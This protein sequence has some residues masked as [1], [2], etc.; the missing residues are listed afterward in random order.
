[1]KA[2]FDPISDSMYLETV[3]E[4]HLP[5]GQATALKLFSVSSPW[6]GLASNSAKAAVAVAAGDAIFGLGHRRYCFWSQPVGVQADTRK[7]GWSPAK[8]RVEKSKHFRAFRADRQ[9]TS[10]FT[11]T[12]S[13]ILAV[14]GLAFVAMAS[15]VQVVQ[16][17]RRR[18]AATFPKVVASHSP[19]AGESLQTRA[20]AI[21]P[22]EGA[23]PCGDTQGLG[24]R[25]SCIQTTG[26]ETQ[27]GKPESYRIMTP[28]GSG[29]NL[30]G[31][32]N[33]FERM[34]TPNIP[35][36]KTDFYFMGTDV[37]AGHSDDQEPAHARGSA[38]DFGH[39][40]LR[41]LRSGDGRG[42]H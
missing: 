31:M 23:V 7:H 37:A 9:T 28:M 32:M 15:C 22:E 2:N 24:C 29:T 11:L 27:T 36:L 30:F 17:S 5:P 40:G 26:T 3:D 41:S 34:Q 38:A 1:M 4:R 8:D 12:G 21:L 14:I 42:N 25:A 20:G 39:H 18:A 35:E 13:T 16:A 10:R 6:T 19:C 33:D